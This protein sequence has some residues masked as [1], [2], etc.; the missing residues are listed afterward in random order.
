M[1][2]IEIAAHLGAYGEPCGQ[3]ATDHG[4]MLAMNAN[5]FWDE[6]EQ[7]NQGNGNGGILAGYTRSNGTAYGKHFT[8]WGYKRLELHEDNL[9]YIKDVGKSVSDDCTDCCEFAPAMIID[10]QQIVDYG[11]TGTHPRAAIGQ[12]DKYEILMLCIEGRQTQSLGTDVNTCIEIMMRHHC[13]QALN[14][15]GGSSAMLWF[16]GKDCISSSS[17][18]LRYLGGRPLPNAWVY[19]TVGWTPES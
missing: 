19:H 5:P 14:L 13:M 11:Y 6:D 7:G 9:M 12:S 8:A 10:G 15:D 16:D 4:G 2:N 1:L 18:P 3:I 17:K